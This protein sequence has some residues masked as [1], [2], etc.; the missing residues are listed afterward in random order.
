MREKK[1]IFIMSHAMELGGAERSLLGLLQT[2]DT[3]QYD[4][5]LFLMRQ[6]GELLQF[7]PENIRLIPQI[8][9]YTVLARPMRET[10]REKHFA[11]TFARM[12]GKIA[13]Y[14]YDQKHGYLDSAVALE[15][16]HKFTK[17]LLPEIAPNMEYD[18]AISFLTPHYYVAEKVRAKQKIAWIHT[19]YSKVEVNRKSELK[20]W[21]K[22]D[23]IVSISDAVTT[24]F[25]QI[26][27]ELEEKV[28]MI[29]NILPKK[30]IEV[31]K[32]LFRV[33]DEMPPKG[34]KLL[35]IGRYCTAKNF[36]NVPEMC[37]KLIN[38]G[39][40]IYWYVIGFGPDERLIRDK[41][42]QFHMENR[43]ILLGKKENPYPYMEACDFYIQP[44]R[45]E[46]KSVTVREAQ[47]LGKPVVIT[48]YATSKSQ[49][50]H[51]IDGII[52]PMDNE[53]CASS[54]GKLIQNKELCE[55]LI[56]NCRSRDYSNANEIEQLYSL[57]A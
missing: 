49:L 1:R 34:I 29:E 46:G 43:V 21:N 32:T 25:L 22:Y 24:G 42:R 39:H 20:M 14:W 15:Y 18:L 51:G 53:E 3:E 41:I 26:F 44:S 52:V 50:D 11:L 10:L 36:D 33:D 38:M 5:D 9:G 27:P 30:L 16:S 56:A 55:Q 8:A 47:M 48:E 35:S 23:H 13:A 45:Y 2:V 17:S 6:E 37:S 54:I 12:L 31:Q 57:L 28:I 4:V 40:D 19:D 7:I